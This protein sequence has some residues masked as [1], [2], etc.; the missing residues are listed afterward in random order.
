MDGKQERDWFKEYVERELSRLAKAVEGM[1]VDLAAL[2]VKVASST[3]LERD[4][5]VVELDLKTVAKQAHEPKSCNQD[6]APLWTKVNHNAERLA[7]LK[8]SAV[9]FGAIA[10]AALNLIMALFGLIKK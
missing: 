8:A 3:E 10:A 4:L 7:A 5:R 6:L 2:S 9:M 1:R